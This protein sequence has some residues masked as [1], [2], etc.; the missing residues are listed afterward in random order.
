MSEQDLLAALG[1][2]A[3]EQEEADP[4]D[5]RWDRLAAGELS[6]EERAELESLAEESDEAAAALATFSPLDGAALDRM[7]DRVVAEQA[8][9][10]V[11]E[12][13]PERVE[14]PAAAPAVVPAEPPASEPERRPGI[15][16]GL[17]AALAY[18][19]RRPALWGATLA[20]AAAVAAALLLVLRPAGGPPLPG[21]QGGVGGGD[22]PAGGAASLPAEVRELTPGSRLEL[23]LRPAS[24]VAGTVVAVTFVV[25]GGEVRP[26]PVLPELSPDGAVRVAGT[27]AELLPGVSGERELVLV[28]GRP[29]EV[30]D[31]AAVRAVLAGAQQPEGWRLLRTRVRLVPP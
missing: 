16:P 6:D 31:A 26:W 25:E 8:A 4:L 21:Y 17:L 7:A 10:R 13:A 28:A 27:A 3:R 14:E 24:A 23:V 22:R 18:P 11:E 20:P 12:P 2:V 29:G 30:P 15:L 5:E 1:R 19:F 9:E